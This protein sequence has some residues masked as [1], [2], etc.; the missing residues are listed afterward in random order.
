MKRLSDGLGV[1]EQISE[2]RNGFEVRP[3]EKKKKDCKTIPDFD[4]SNSI[5]GLREHSDSSLLIRLRISRRDCS[6]AIMGENSGNEAKP[7]GERD[8]YASI[9]A[10]Q[11]L[12]SL[13][14]TSRALGK[15]VSILKDWFPE[16]DA[17]KRID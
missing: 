9:S 1:P 4:I 12:G 6:G 16:N 11:Q 5:F 17:N 3:R 10:P 14:G 7:D 15:Q 8:I 2:L 13:R